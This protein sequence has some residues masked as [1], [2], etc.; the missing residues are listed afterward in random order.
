MHATAADALTAGRP[1]SIETLHATP[2]SAVAQA[3]VSKRDYEFLAGAPN[4]FSDD[5]EKKAVAAFRL[6]AYQ[7]GP[8]SR[9]LVYLGSQLHSALI[10]LVDR[11][12]TPSLTCG[13]L[14]QWASQAGLLP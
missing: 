3:V 6:L 11:S 12:R 2:L 14:H 1:A 5:A 4:L 13:G 8:A 7:S 9:W 10:T